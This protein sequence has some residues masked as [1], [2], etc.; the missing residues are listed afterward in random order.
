MNTQT[1]PTANKPLSEALENITP[2][3]L[4]KMTDHFFRELPPSDCINML[5]ELL[6]SES[7]DS[8]VSTK[9]VDDIY[10]M[11]SFFKEVQSM[12]N[13]KK[14]EQA[15]ALRKAEVRIAERFKGSN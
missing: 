7:R 6:I 5:F 10:I 11:Y 12:A 15:A 13:Q 1:L 8:V 9:T 2:D 14:K 3:E 4:F